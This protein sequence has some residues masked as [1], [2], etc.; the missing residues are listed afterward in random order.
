MRSLRIRKVFGGDLMLSRAIKMVALQVIVL[1]LC[2]AGDKLT[3]DPGV[4]GVPDPCQSTASIATPGVCYVACPIGSCSRLEDIGATI[5]I[6]VKDSDGLPIPDISIFDIWLSSCGDGLV[7]CALQHFGASPDSAT[8]VD[9][10]TTL[11]QGLEIGGCDLSGLSV[12]VQGVQLVE[13]DCVTVR[14]LDIDIISADINGDCRVDL[15]DLSEFSK[16][17]TS[18][19][20]PYFP[21]KDYDCN[22]VID[23]VDFSLFSRHYLHV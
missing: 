1:L 23:L 3:A 12:W 20:A 5:F 15:I 13:A 16:S 4:T 9:G 21:C 7:D 22:G 19:P 6:T 18:P 8:Y 14:C 10:T 11:S 17:Y 2:L